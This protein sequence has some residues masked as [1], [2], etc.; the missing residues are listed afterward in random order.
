MI[1]LRYAARE[2]FGKHASNF[3]ELM[4]ACA[5]IKINCMEPETNAGDNSRQCAEIC[6]KKKVQQIT[7][8]FP[9]VL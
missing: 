1:Y 6:Q 7:P 4:I 8:R 2:E 9:L 5:P 3:L